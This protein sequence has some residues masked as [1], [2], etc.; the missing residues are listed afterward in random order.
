[1]SDALFIL[2][3]SIF[4]N[5]NY[6]LS[7]IFKRNMEYSSIKFESQLVKKLKDEKYY[8]ANRIVNVHFYSNEMNDIFKTCIYLFSWLTIL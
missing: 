7:N 4:K 6:K 3:I 8:F 2:E 5:K 1:M